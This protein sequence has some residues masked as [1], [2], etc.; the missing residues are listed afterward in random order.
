MKMHSG[1]PA[2]PVVKAGDE[3][4]M[5]QLIG[6]MGGFVSSPIHASVS[7]CVTRINDRDPVTGQKAVSISIASDGLNKLCPNIKKATIL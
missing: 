1:K 5:G 7:G 4:K 6:E 2:V 3:V